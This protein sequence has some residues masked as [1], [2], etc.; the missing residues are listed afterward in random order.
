MD[1]IKCYD[2]Y[3]IVSL[4]FFVSKDVLY[5]RGGTVTPPP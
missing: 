5:I 3:G 2:P 1:I 4:D